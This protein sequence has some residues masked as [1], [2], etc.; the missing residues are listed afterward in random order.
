MDVV[1]QREI[2]K[3]III[4]LSLDLLRIH[5]VVWERSVPAGLYRDGLLSYFAISRLKVL[6]IL[7][8]LVHVLA[9]VVVQVVLTARRDDLRG[10]KATADVTY[11]FLSLDKRDISVVACI[12]IKNVAVIWQSATCNFKIH[13]LRRFRGTYPFSQ[14]GVCTALQEVQL[15]PASFCLTQLIMR[16]SL[17]AVRELGWEIFLGR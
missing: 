5:L 12:I 10:E 13:V 16:V 2:W 7:V 1:Q 14:C 11:S 8:L 17:L 4:T 15:L 6:S 3:I 9:L